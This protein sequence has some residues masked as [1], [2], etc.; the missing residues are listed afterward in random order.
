MKL[1]D[2]LELVTYETFAPV[3]AP[4]INIYADDRSVEYL[5]VSI[6]YYRDST[7]VAKD[8]L[9]G[10]IMEFI[11]CNGAVDIVLNDDSLNREDEDEG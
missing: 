4:E 9:D 2:F 5:L 1:R 7:V 8:I 11:F 3:K 10:E 6:N